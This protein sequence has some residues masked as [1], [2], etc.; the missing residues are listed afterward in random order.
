V[1]PSDCNIPPW[2]VSVNTIHEWC[3]RELTA[4]TQSTWD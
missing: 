4:Y 3:A 2:C 1:N